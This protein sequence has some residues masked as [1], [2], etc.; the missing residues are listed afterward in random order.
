VRVAFVSPLPPEPTGIADYAADVLALLA[1]RHAIDVFHGQGAAD[2]AR[3]P[4]A[5]LAFPAFELGARHRARPYD[6]IVYQIGNGPAHA[7]QYA[8]LSR[9]PGLLVLHDLV[10]HHSRAAQFLESDAVRAWRREPGSD[11]A[12]EAARPSLEAW[13]AELLYSYPDEAAR[14]FEAHLGTVGDL[15]PY[16]YPLFRIPVEASRAVAVHNAF[17]AEAIKAEVPDAETLRI[18]MPASAAAVDPAAV[19]ALRRR[20]GFAE[21]DVVVGS[22]GLLTP[23]KRIE[24]TARAVARAAAW[25]PHLRLLLAGPVPDPGRLERLLA[26]LGVAPRTVVTGRVPLESLPAHVEAADVVVHLR[27]PTGR[28]TSAALL[29]VLAQGRATVLSDLEHQADL[30]D[31]AVVR[32]DVAD[33]EGETTRAILRL[34]GD[35]EAR[36]R[37]GE[38]AASFVAIAHAPPRALEA[39][40]VALERT[41][42]RPD[43]TPRTWPPHWPRPQPADGRPRGRSG[44]RDAAEGD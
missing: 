18:P 32:V 38:A 34:A 12:R 21:D 14:L 22:F 15:L 37:L 31:E 27:Y 40:E 1:P 11:A 9:L 25:N 23:E 30:P 16:A 19:R 8:L 28:E 33:E 26:R 35:P 7:F 4:G 6:A 17:M 43:P 29:R 24:T 13:R 10:L 39:Y 36:R 44:G 3:L 41:R 2:P 42:Q 5:C 20:L